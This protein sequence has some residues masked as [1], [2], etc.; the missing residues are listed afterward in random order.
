MDVRLSE[1][2]GLPLESR[3]ASSRR[4]VGLVA[5]EF[6]FGELAAGRLISAARARGKNATYQSGTCRTCDSL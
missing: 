3:S 2:L 4:N 5:A 6:T 1:A